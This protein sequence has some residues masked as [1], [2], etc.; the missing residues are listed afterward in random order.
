[1]DA[2]LL[3][4]FS[5]LVLFVCLFVCF[6]LLDGTV[7]CELALMGFS[8]AAVWFNVEFVSRPCSGDLG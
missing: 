6:L 7:S 1:M 2:E 8:E 4:A 5:S 3:C